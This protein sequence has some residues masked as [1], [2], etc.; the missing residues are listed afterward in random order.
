MKITKEEPNRNLL[1]LRFLIP[2]YLNA[3]WELIRS[4]TMGY[5]YGPEYQEGWF[6]ILLRMIGLV[7]P[8]ISAHSP[9]NYVNSVRLGMERI[10]QISS[11]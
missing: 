1:G 6:S 4:L 8:G 5:T 10:V 9:R 11:F 2:L 7:L 3:A